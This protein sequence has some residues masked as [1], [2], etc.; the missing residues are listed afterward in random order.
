MTDEKER[1]QFFAALGEALTEWARVENSLY[2]VFMFCLRAPHRSAAA[3][4]FAVDS[5]RSKLKM[6]D[7]VVR[8]ARLDAAKTDK[9]NGLR[10]RI[11]RKST[12]RNRLAHHEVLED[13]SAK[14]GKRFLLRNKTLDPDPRFLSVS[15]DKGL[16]TSDLRDRRL[17]F[18]Q[19][20]D[21]MARFYG[22]L[23]KDLGMP[24]H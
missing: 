8:E 5:L 16:R 24:P 9:W 6:A 14:P 15:E 11:D 10:D 23:C 22:E 21:D 7:S 20:A 17:E 2:L 12:L 1:L 18:S 19:L 3:A 4:F 13:P